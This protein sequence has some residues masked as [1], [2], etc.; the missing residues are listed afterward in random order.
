MDRIHRLGLEEDIET[1]IEIL[2]TPKSIDERVDSRLE[3]KIQLMFNVLNDKSLNVEPE[4][5][6]LDE[7]GFNIDDAED[8]IGHLEH[9]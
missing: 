3:M 1:T 4:T 2:K 6:E 7:T 5:V 9:H 8:L